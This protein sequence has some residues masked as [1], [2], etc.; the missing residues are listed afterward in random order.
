MLRIL[1][2]DELSSIEGILKIFVLFYLFFL[3]QD[4]YYSGWGYNYKLQ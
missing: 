2:I 4:S 3:E 1:L